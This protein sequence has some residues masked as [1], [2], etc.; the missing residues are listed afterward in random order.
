MGPAP[1]RLIGALSDRCAIEP[2]SPRPRF[3]RPGLDPMFLGRGS[4]SPL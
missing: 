4:L 2:E 1:A 3:S